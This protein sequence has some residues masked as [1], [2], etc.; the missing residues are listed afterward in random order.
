MRFFF[1]FFTFFQV[2]IVRQSLLSDSPISPSCSTSQ[3]ALDNIRRSVN[4]TKF[5]LETS[6]FK[7]LY[8]TVFRCLSLFMIGT[9]ISLE[10]FFFDQIAHEIFLNQNFDFCGSYFQFLSWNWNFLTYMERN[11][12]V[13]INFEDLAVTKYLFL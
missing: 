12:A 4:D 7:I 13:M 5:T 9:H 8:T 6:I 3:A 2:Q 11:T 10:Q 1:F